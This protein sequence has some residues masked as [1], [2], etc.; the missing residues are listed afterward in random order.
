MALSSGQISVLDEAMAPSWALS[1]SSSLKQV[2]ADPTANI[3]T[4]TAI[5]DTATASADPSPSTTQGRYLRMHGAVCTCQSCEWCGGAELEVL[6]TPA[7]S[8]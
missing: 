8:L 1:T 5:A 6:L 2:S 7:T 4:S 3:S